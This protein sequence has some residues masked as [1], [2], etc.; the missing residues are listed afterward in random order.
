[1]DHIH[2]AYELFVDVERAKSF[3]E[4]YEPKN[5]VIGCK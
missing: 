4:L 3:I 2:Q 1:M 5:L